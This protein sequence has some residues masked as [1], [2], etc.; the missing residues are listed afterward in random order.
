M[1]NNLI[2]LSFSI[3]VTVTPTGSQVKFSNEFKEV[4]LYQEV[5]FSFLRFNFFFYL[6]LGVAK[7]IYV[8]RAPPYSDIVLF[9]LSLEATLSSFPLR[10]PFRASPQG[11]KTR[12]LGEDFHTLISVVCSPFELF[13]ERT[14][15]GFPSRV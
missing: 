11:F 12:L 2:N 9:G 4:I 1:K 15:S 8:T 14:L 3:I 13:L 6:V 5:L 7:I 10:G